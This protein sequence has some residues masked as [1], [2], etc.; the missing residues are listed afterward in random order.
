VLDL[1]IYI[2]KLGWRKSQGDHLP[3]PHHH[4]PET[5]STPGGGKFFWKPV[6]IKSALDVAGEGGPQES[7]SP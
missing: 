2:A 4:L 6:F 5:T 1:E 7:T 3:N